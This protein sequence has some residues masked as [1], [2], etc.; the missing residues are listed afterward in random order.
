[1]KKSITFLVV[2]F[3]ISSIIFVGCGISRMINQLGDAF[4]SMEPPDIK[5]PIKI[6]QAKS[7]VVYEVWVNENL[8]SGIFSQAPDRSF[9]TR[10]IVSPLYEDVNDPAG[11]YNLNTIEKWIIWML[12][13]NSNIYYLAK[14]I[15]S[16][17]TTYN[18]AYQN[19]KNAFLNTQKECEIIFNNTFFDRSE[20]EKITKMKE[21]LNIYLD[22]NAKYKFDPAILV[23]PQSKRNLEISGGIAKLTGDP[24]YIV[25]ND[26]SGNYQADHPISVLSEKN[27]DTT[28]A[29]T[30]KNDSNVSLEKPIIEKPISTTETPILK[31]N[32]TGLKFGL[33]NSKFSAE[34]Y[35]VLTDI[36]NYLLKYPKK[37]LEIR[38]YTDAV[39]ATSFNQALSQKRADIIKNYF[40]SNG[41]S[42]SRLISL[43]YG[44]N[45]PI[46]DNNNSEG[47]ALN[48]RIEFQVI[49]PLDMKQVS[50]EN[51]LKASIPDQKKD[52]NPELVVNKE[53]ISNQ[54][55]NSK[56]NATND[57]Q[58]SSTI[59]FMENFIGS[60]WYWPSAE[61][62]SNLKG[63]SIVTIHGFKSLN[64]DYVPIIVDRG[65]GLGYFTVGGNTGVAI[66]GHGRSNNY[67]V[68]DIGYIFSTSK[69][70]G[71]YYSFAYG[72]PIVLDKKKS[73][74]FDFGTAYIGSPTLF[75][76]I[77]FQL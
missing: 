65:I 24:D 73:I 77:G 22:E 43:G 15:I 25:K 41:I 27:N 30:L 54:T 69:L 32:I 37:Q 57:E 1:M 9:S 38:S 3:S 18:E 48:N 36:I 64:R 29:V 68:L 63:Y 46:A 28:T 74:I 61:N 11:S 39:G 40:I 67:L 44:K 47:R 10:I 13:D 17:G 12:D 55:I 70:K 23:I 49:D 31:W 34:S 16:N 56:Y 76:R 71:L 21:P 7:W 4:S 75:I 20:L 62:Y 14:R 19:Y 51:Q 72:I 35:P 42:T 8:S 26:S 50:T 66:F 5:I 58:K 60:Q 6:S 53:I 33:N 52:S 59:Y 45:D 2:F